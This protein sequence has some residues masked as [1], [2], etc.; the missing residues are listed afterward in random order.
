MAVALWEAADKVES[1]VFPPDLFHYSIP[2]LPFPGA[3]LT[4]CS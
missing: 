3:Q 4:I 1:K 2:S